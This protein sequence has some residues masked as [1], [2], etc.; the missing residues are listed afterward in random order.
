MSIYYVDQPS[1]RFRIRVPVRL[2]VARE[3]GSYVFPHITGHFMDVMNLIPSGCAADSPEFSGIYRCHSADV[4]EAVEQLLKSFVR[5]LLM[6]GCLSQNMSWKA[7]CKVGSVIPFGG[8]MRV[9]PTVLFPLPFPL[10][11]FLAGVRFTPSLVR[12]IDHVSCNE[13]WLSSALEPLREVDPF[14]AQLLD[15]CRDVY[16]SGKR[17][18]RDD[19]RAYITRADYLLHLAELQS[20]PSNASSSGRMEHCRTCHY[21]VCLCELRNIV[22]GTIGSNAGLMR[23]FETLPGVYMRMVEVNTV[24]CALAHLSELVSRAHSDCV[25]GMLRQRL[26]IGKMDHMGMISGFHKLHLQNSPLGGIVDTL[27]TAHEHYVKRHCSLMHDMPPCILQVVTEEL[28]NFFDVYAVA[29]VLVENYG[30]TV[31]VVTM[32]ELCR[33]RREGRLFVQTA[34]DSPVHL[35]EPKRQFNPD[36]EGNPGRLF[37]AC[38]PLNGS[39]QNEVIVREVSVIY[40]RSCYSDDEMSC[41]RDS[42]DVR[43]LF[44]F[45]DAVKVPSVPAQLAGSKRI[46]MLLCDPAVRAQLSTEDT[47]PPDVSPTGASISPVSAA[48]NTF[49]SVNVQQVDPSLDAHEEI[50]KAAIEA[51]AG[52]VLKSQAEGGAELYTHDKL[53]EVLRNGMENDRRQLARYVLMRRIKPPVQRAA[54]VKGTEE[55]GFTLSV[56]RTVTEIGIYG[57]AVFSGKRVLAEECSGYLARTKN[58]STAGGGVCAGH[59]AVSSLLFF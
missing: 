5:K 14:M 58:E 15:I 11:P 39:G 20:A 40:Y 19:V 51:P 59:A 32:R 6:L 46:Q 33:W 22:G 27:A 23:S 29:D 4:S 8:R 36:S 57:C 3:D 49:R 41:D 48:L 43:R 34:S 7:T 55:D 31:K 16:L 13:Q 30:V 1:R 38:P 47:L 52:F 54:F 17:R 24:S 45:S 28:G 53:A 44:E 2:E 35:V 25:D 21:D 56:E 26:A 37:I 10:S 12:L 9:A 18:L 42:W 50:V